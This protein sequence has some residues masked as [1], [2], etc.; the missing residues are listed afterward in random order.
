MTGWQWRYVHFWSPFRSEPL[1]EKFFGNIGFLMEIAKNTYIC[2]HTLSHPTIFRVPTSDPGS[3]VRTSVLGLMGAGATLQTEWHI[4]ATSESFW[5]SCG[6]KLDVTKLFFRFPSRKQRSEHV[7][8]VVR[9]GKQLC[10]PV[11]PPEAES[12]P[13][14]IQLTTFVKSWIFYPQAN[15]AK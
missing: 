6:A 9:G 15:S 5:K 1:T 3:R 14:Y 8:P 11:V 4:S 2:S 10:A 13:E 7:R 12:W